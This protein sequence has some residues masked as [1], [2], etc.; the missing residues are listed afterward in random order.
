MNVVIGLENT[1]VTSC[2]YSYSPQERT[3]T[4]ATTMT[5]QLPAKSKKG[6]AKAKKKSTYSFSS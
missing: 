2:S 4:L 3:G 1:E 5:G 6:T